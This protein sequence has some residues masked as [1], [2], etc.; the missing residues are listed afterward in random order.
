MLEELAWGMDWR[1]ASLEAR[2]PRGESRC[3]HPG[4]SSGR[5]EVLAWE[6]S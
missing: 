2:N 5:E 4:E 6:L 1:G 3:Q